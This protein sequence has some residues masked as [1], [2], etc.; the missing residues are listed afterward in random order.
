MLRVS[1]VRQDAEIFM[2][3]FSDLS[4]LEYSWQ[5]LLSL[6]LKLVA[7]LLQ[8]LSQENLDCQQL[9]QAASLRFWRLE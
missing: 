8:A 7:Q 2:R 6:T 5:I 3:E 4:L 1:Y 9:E